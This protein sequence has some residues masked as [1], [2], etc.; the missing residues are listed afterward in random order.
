MPGAVTAQQ[1]ANTKAALAGKPLPYQ[2]GF[3]EAL[4][5][6]ALPLFAEIAPAFP[7]AAAA[8]KAPTVAGAGAG[9]AG[10]AAGALENQGKQAAENLLKGKVKKGL[11]NVAKDAGSAAAKGVAALSVGALFTDIG[12]WKGLGMVIAGGILIL[13][14]ILNLAGVDAG[15]IARRVIP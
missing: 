15:G 11:G 3:L 1:A 9:A 4:A 13:I 5:Q 14:G 10:A 12:L 6:D 7:E 8:I 2:T